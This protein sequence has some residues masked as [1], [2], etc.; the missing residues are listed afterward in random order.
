[1]PATM[2]SDHTTSAPIQCLG[3]GATQNL[4]AGSTS[5]QNGTAFPA[6]ATVLRIA[7]VDGAIYYRT[8][9]NPTAAAGTAG[10]FLP[11]GAVEYRRINPGEKLAVIR[12][13]DADVIVNVEACA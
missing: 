11:E 8:G 5:T 13:G 6:D 9:A 10:S 3:Q 2:A 1:M 7:A 12:A 4:T